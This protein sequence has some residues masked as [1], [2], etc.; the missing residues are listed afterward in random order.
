MTHFGRHDKDSAG[1]WKVL[2]VDDEPSVHDVSRL[3]LSDLEFA[4]RPVRLLHA[5]SA[6]TAQQ[7]LNH[8]TDIALLI[9]D[10]VMETDEAGLDLIE[11]VRDEMNN[12]QIQIVLR[13]GQ[14]GM[15]PETTIIRRFAINGYFVK[16]EITAQRLESIV[17]SSLRSF[18]QLRRLAN[19]SGDS[20]P[21]PTG[22]LRSTSPQP[23]VK[24]TIG[25]IEVAALSMQIQPELT[26]I[27]NQVSGA[28]LIPHWRTPR[29]LLS[30]SRIIQLAPD[31]NLRGARALW[32]LDQA[33]RWAASWQTTLGRCVTV[34]LPLL[35]DCLNDEMILA[36]ILRE[37]RHS[38]LPPGAIDILAS[39]RV[40]LHGDERIAVS[41]ASLRSA[42]AS[43]TLVNF[44]ELDIPLLRLNR[45]APDRIKIHRLYVSGVSASPERMAMARS[46][47]ALAHTMNIVAIADGI[48]SDDDAQFFKWEGCDIGQG[49]GI[50][51]ACAPADLNKPLVQSRQ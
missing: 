3:I 10:V 21:A 38:G 13:T 14:P 45:F 43:I 2:L 29:G 34:S 5:N 8:H 31:D 22:P 41:L 50:A 19:A 7:L 6:A 24:E 15:A 16:T 17:I 44:G 37:I 20:D 11:H 25:A 40:L 51:P 28:E 27:T 39:E 35:A 1:P 32:L 46:L 23:I 36:D 4:N 42:G 9:L 33:V 48:A 30:A 12:H 18:E 26:L 49:N 47:I